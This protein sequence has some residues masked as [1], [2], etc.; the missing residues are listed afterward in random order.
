[1]ERLHKLLAQAGYGS[2][3]QIE[4]WIQAGRVTVNGQPAAV[5]AS[6]QGDETICIDG[7]PVR[8]N[9]VGERG[10]QVLLYHKPDG[11]V[12]TQKD[13]E[14][15]PTVFEHLPRP[16]G[17]KWIAVGRLDINSSGLLLFT[18]D[19]ELANGLMHPSA[20]V[21]RE[22][23]V[24]VR[25]EVTPEILTR[26]TR[27]VELE[28]GPARFK[29]IQ[30]RGGTG[31]NQWFHVILSEGR[32]REVRRLWASQG[33]TV[34]RLMRVRYGPLALPPQ[35]RRGRSRLATDEEVAALRQ[36][37]GLAEV[38]APIV[39]TKKPSEQKGKKAP[40][41]VPSAPAD[42]RPR[43][44][45]DGRGTRQGGRDHERGKESPSRRTSAPSKKS[46]QHKARRR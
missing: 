14:G 1:M 32:N 31:S 28:D 9:R 36:A 27:G 22:Y 10:Y 41:S 45:S 16:K 29:A 18:N 6:V 39:K 5:G 11:E 38:P 19:G 8:L 43:A 35:L 13:P 24:R 20:Q 12:V 2:R 17:G 4:T 42:K 33:I 34:S 26:L 37:A 46:A 40:R 23:A 30:E 7:Q 21:E 25:G 44:R 15:R 3:R